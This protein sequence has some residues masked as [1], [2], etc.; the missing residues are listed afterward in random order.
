VRA[1]TRFGSI[2][3]VRHRSAV[4]EFFRGGPSSSVTTLLEALAAIE[5]Q[6]ARLDQQLKEVALRSRSAGG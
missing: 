6:I 1:A 4:E 3:A 2:A 5:A